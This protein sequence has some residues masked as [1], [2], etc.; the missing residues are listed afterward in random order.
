MQTNL[1]E[2]VLFYFIVKDNSNTTNIYDVVEDFT[3]IHVTHTKNTKTQNN[4]NLHNFN[5]NIG[6]VTFQRKRFVTIPDSHISKFLYFA[7]EIR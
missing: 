1:I 6:N 4:N 2:R 7:K 3:N 5:V